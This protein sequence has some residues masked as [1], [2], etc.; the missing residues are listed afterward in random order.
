[1]ND[2][3]SLTETIERKDPFDYL[4]FLS[5]YPLEE[6][7]ELINRLKPKNGI[8]LNWDK[9]LAWRKGNLNLAKEELL[10]PILFDDK[11]NGK[12]GYVTKKLTTRDAKIGRLYCDNCNQPIK[13]NEPSQSI[14][15][16]EFSK[17]IE[18]INQQFK[19]SKISQDIYFDLPNQGHNI[20]GDS[21]SLSILI[22]LLHQT[23][24]LE[25]PSQWYF[26][27]SFSEKHFC[28]V[29]GLESKLKAF[30]RNGGKKLFLIEGQSDIATDNTKAEI[31]LLNKE[32]LKAIYEYLNHLRQVIPNVGLFY[33]YFF[34]KSHK[35]ESNLMISNQLINH[36]AVAGL[37]E[38]KYYASKLIGQHHLH[39]GNSQEADNWFAKSNQHALSKNFFKIDDALLYEFKLHFPANE[40]INLIDSGHFNKDLSCYHEIKAK[41]K[42]YTKVF[43]DLPTTPL[44]YGLFAIKNSLAFLYDFA[45]RWHND[46]ADLYSSLENRLYFKEYWPEIWA[47]ECRITNINDKYRQ[48]NG[49]ADT[50]FS[51]FQINEKI[52]LNDFQI[53][54]LEDF[55]KNNISQT[56]F[57]LLACLKMQIMQNGQSS[58][59]D[60]F[61]F[62]ETLYNNV[63]AHAKPDNKDELFPLV[64]AIELYNIYFEKDGF[65]KH[66]ALENAKAWFSKQSI[67]KLLALR[68][69]HSFNEEYNGLIDETFCHNYFLDLKNHPHQIQTRC[70]Y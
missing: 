60:L 58:H 39:L 66:F 1:M 59:C 36:F 37:S 8:N 63:H 9:Y 28:P 6:I 29:S 35:K 56:N 50:Q 14:T 30:H 20:T 45:G 38:E 47:E 25:I 68:T 3:I 43:E 24:G 51:L 32:P 4:P 16:I 18:L 54:Y 12:L 64:R 62:K 49:I 52:T 19:F 40:V 42:F 27:G 34:G 69:F 44:A 46:K 61:K 31:I 10:A 67:L 23:L 65:L 5:D 55:C 15:P 48:Y 2:E 13:N 57:N 33:L 26:S 7:E 53:S 41:D 17:I 11:Q 21:C 22:F 70:P